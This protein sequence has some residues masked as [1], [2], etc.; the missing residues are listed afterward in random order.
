[1]KKTKSEIEFLANHFGKTDEGFDLAIST[2]GIWYL[3]I[4][5]TKEELLKVINK[6]ASEDNMIEVKKMFDIADK[7]FRE[8]KNQKPI[9][10]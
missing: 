8:Y 10:S 1:M 9:E 5:N 2:L 6:D 3:L 4:K 7:L